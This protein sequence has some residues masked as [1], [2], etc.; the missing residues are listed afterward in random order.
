MQKHFLMEKFICYYNN[1]IN[2]YNR[3]KDVFSKL[4]FYVELELKFSKKNPLVAL[5]SLHR[6]DISIPEVIRHVCT[7]RSA[8][9]ESIWD[10]PGA[11][12]NTG[13]SRSMIEVVAVRY[14]RLPML[15]AVAYAEVH[16]YVITHVMTKRSRKSYVT[17]T[18]NLHIWKFIKGNRHIL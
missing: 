6:V 17:P 11:S 14:I 13:V 3:I 18:Q 16:T 1:H 4:I 7:T 8:R 5:I 2:F 10:S 9:R 12:R 15:N